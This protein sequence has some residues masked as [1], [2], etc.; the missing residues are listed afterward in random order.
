M[1]TIPASPL[2]PPVKPLVEVTL[3][4]LHGISV[5][6]SVLQ[7]AQ[8]AA[9][10]TE[11]F[12]CGSNPAA[13]HLHMRRKILL[14]KI[15]AS[16]A[17]SGTTKNIEVASSVFCP[18]TNK[19]TV[20]S[21]PADIGTRPRSVK[22]RSERRFGFN[23]TDTTDPV[24]VVARWTE[25]T[26]RTDPADATPHMSMHLP[27][28]DPRIPRMSV[29]KANRDSRVVTEQREQKEPTENTRVKE[30]D[31]ESR[32][33]SNDI[34]LLD[35]L[36]GSTR[37]TSVLEKRSTYSS[38]TGGRISSVV[39][40]SGGM[41][42]IL[43]LLTAIR[44]DD[45]KEE[46][47]SSKNSTDYRN[48][49]SK[50]YQD[51]HERMNVAIET[52][53]DYDDVLAETDP[54][55]EASS[56]WTGPISFEVGIAH[57]V[58]FGSEAG[59]TVLDLPIKFK[60]SLS[61]LPPNIAVSDQAYLRVKIRVAHKRPPVVLQTKSRL[62]EHQEERTRLLVG[63]ILSQLKQ[64]EED[65]LARKT[66]RSV[67]VP[68]NLNDSAR[69]GGCYPSGLS[70]NPMRDGMCDLGFTGMLR[71]WLNEPKKDPSK[72][73][74]AKCP[75]ESGAPGLRPITFVK[76]KRPLKANELY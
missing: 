74:G 27:A 56:G 36:S 59:V 51:E 24:A 37:S 28:Q 65:M 17:F 30:I 11:P 57:L 58:F 42:D 71:D 50:G 29:S 61:S 34:P 18:L 15:T 9:S 20:E 62:R 1:Y 47:L 55:D 32:E 76:S 2:K 26:G 16:V 13:C 48:E 44:V 3:D 10:D 60:K 72:I 66:R 54:N 19:L 33:S 41:P 75:S 45:A 68:L 52:N 14:P 64:A 25:G 22:S 5:Q 38:Q 69:M 23:T 73:Q 53:I 7:V 43:E 21:H 49:K 6:P 40:S 67:S 8:L 70:Q 12:H 4:S 35:E 46:I 39:W 31:F 63:P